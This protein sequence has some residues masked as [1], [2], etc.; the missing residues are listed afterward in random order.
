MIAALNVFCALVLAVA[1]DRLGNEG[2]WGA[3]AVSA[4]IGICN[5]WIALHSLDLLK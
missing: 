4:A 1:C 5:V 2:H 3:V